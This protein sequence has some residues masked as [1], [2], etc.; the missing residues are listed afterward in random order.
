MYIIR[1]CDS[2]NNIKDFLFIFEKK[3]VI[4]KRVCCNLICIFMIKIVKCK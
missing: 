2:L 1:K 3:N 4:F